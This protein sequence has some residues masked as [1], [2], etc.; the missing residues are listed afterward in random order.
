MQDWADG[1]VG[2]RKW[3]V[4]REEGM[5]IFVPWRNVQTGKEEP[6]VAIK[7]EQPW[8]KWKGHG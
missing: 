4:F 6:S 2:A 1:Y 7:L 3:M 5:R 8:S